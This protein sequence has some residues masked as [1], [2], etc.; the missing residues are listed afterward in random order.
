A[1]I[2]LVPLACRRS[3][4]PDQLELSAK[5]PCTST[6]VN[7][8]LGVDW[9]IVMAPCE[10]SSEREHERLDATVGEFDLEQAVVDRLGLPDQLVHAL[11]VRRA[12][13]VRVDVDAPCGPGDLAVEPDAER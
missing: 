2:T 5:A 4:T 13:P 7:G 12:V 9:D 10:L 11:V 8:E 1:A 6:T 3:M